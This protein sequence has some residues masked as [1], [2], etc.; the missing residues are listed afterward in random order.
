MSAV[1]MDTMKDIYANLRNIDVQDFAETKGSAN[2]LYLPWAKAHELMMENYPD[3]N[4]DWEWSEDGNPY[5]MTD[6]GYFVIV[7]VKVTDHERSEI[8]PVTDYNNKVLTSPTAFDINTAIRR[9]YVKTLAQ[10]GLGLQLYIGGTPKPAPK[11]QSKK[12]A[13]KPKVK[14]AKETPITKSITESQ[15]ERLRE[16]CRDEKVSDKTVK[17]IADGVNGTKGNLFTEVMAEQQ[18]KLLE[19]AMENV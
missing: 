19:K 16:L 18:I 10:F 5:F 15:I 2:L 13:P 12:P 7:K 8:L 14:V 9:C 11:K 3:Y 6:T 17:H 1:D 4:W